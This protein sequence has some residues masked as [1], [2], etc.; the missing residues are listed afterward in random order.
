[1]G[2]VQVTQGL[3]PDPENEGWYLGWG[4]AKNNPWHLAAVCASE[5]EAAAYAKKNFVE[6]YQVGFGSHRLGT[7]EFIFS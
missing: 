6:S 5:G 7:D 2:S 3:K 1:M 4:V